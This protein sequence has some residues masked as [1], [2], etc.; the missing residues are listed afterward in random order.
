MKIVVW[1][2]MKLGDVMYIGIC[3]MLS[4]KVEKNY[5]IYNV[6]WQSLHQSKGQTDI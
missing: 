4:V 6:S 5:T 2:V 1:I 3:Q